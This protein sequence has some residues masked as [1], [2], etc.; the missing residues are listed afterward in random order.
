MVI[1]VL[2]ASVGGVQGISSLFRLHENWLNY[3]TAAELIR[4]EINLYEGGVDD[5]A[6]KATAPSLL[7]KRVEA[8]G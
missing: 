4:R 3:R 6:N 5:Y 7:V 1:S 2:A 8:L